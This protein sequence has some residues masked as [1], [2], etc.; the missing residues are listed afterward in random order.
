MEPDDDIA[1]MYA[2]QADRLLSSAYFAA[3]WGGIA[4]VAGAA[5]AAGNADN[6]WSGFAAFMT[7]LGVGLALTSALYAGMN[8]LR[9]HALVAA[10]RYGLV[11][12]DEAPPPRPRGT[13]PP[14]T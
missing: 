12:D 6:E 11:V 14:L 1:R 13:R 8:A 10:A 2:G 9:T 5:W 3:S 7:V 4:S